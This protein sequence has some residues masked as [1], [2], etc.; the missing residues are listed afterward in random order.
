MW[1]RDTNV[2]TA[3]IVTSPVH[4]GSKACHIHHWGLQDWS[5]EPQAVVAVK[6]GQLYEYSAWVRV[7]S[8]AAGGV[9]QIG[10]VLRD[11]R[12]SVTRL[13]VCNCLM[14]LVA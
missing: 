1:T 12:D 11:T 4:S 5:L 14:H 3:Q 7:D 9:V 10:T 6:P 8:L 13:V 2:G